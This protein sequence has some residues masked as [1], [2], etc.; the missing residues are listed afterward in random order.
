MPISGLTFLGVPGVPSVNPISIRGTDYAHLITT[1]IP[2]FSDLPTALQGYY[3]L[4]NPALNFGKIV[5][6]YLQCTL[7]LLS[8]ISTILCFLYNH[9]VVSIINQSFSHLK[10]KITYHGFDL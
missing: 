2:G 4:E 9:W 7:V 10:T 1:G 8:Y 6:I 5:N 3:T